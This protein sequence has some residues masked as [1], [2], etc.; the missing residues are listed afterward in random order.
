MK[1]SFLLAM[2]PDHT[3]EGRVRKVAMTTDTLDEGGPQVLVTASVDRDAL[4]RLRPGASVVA[5]IDC[6]RR[7]LG[8]VWLHDVWDAVRTRV[9]F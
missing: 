9:L 5:K 1:L 2:D 4:P 6:G 3:Y 7:S 8:F